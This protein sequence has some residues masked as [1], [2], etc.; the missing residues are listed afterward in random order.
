MEALYFLAQLFIFGLELKKK[1]QQKTMFKSSHNE[2]GYN[3]N[4]PEYREV[5][6][7]GV[8]VSKATS[9]HYHT[10]MVIEISISENRK[11]RIS[12]DFFGFHD[13]ITR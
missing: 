13:R 10:Q 11:S 9:Q 2:N 12:T 6:V 7:R 4:Q 1:R 8:L 5:V 3:N